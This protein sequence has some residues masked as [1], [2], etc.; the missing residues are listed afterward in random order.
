MS[1]GMLA[2]LFWFLSLN[3]LWG[4][5]KGLRTGQVAARGFTIREAANPTLF[6]LAILFR[7]VIVVLAV[8]Q[9]LYA[10]GLGSDPLQQVQALLPLIKRPPC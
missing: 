7:L 3:A 8:A 6:A 1:P 5:R 4:I 2:L 10:L 9:T